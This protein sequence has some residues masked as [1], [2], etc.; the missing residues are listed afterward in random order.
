MRN[1]VP[2]PTTTSRRPV[3]CT[4]VFNVAAWTAPTDTTPLVS[5]RVVFSRVNVLLVTIDV[6]IVPLTTL[7]D[8]MTL[9]DDVASRN[10][11]GVRA[12]LMVVMFA[13]L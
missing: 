9:H 6:S 11:H 8:D 1:R 10:T 4:W 2:S 13:P 3:H 7:I 5:S 12:C